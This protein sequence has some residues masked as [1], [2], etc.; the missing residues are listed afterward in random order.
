MS[1]LATTSEG[2]E[3]LGSADPLKS[4][5]KNYL[6]QSA[7]VADPGSG[8]DFVSSRICI[9]EFKYGILTQKV[10]SKVSD[11]RFGLFTPDPDPEFITHPGSRIQGSKKGTGSRIRSTAK[12]KAYPTSR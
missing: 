5:L 4:S 10:V 2:P 8:S 1:F 11:I 3:K 7:C 6:Y 12:C 9:K